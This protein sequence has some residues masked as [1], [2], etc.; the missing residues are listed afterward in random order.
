MTATANYF[1]LSHHF[2]LS[3]EVTLFC[4]FKRILL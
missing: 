1:M 4:V 2:I 3:T